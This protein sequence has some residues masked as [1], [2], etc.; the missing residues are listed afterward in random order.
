MAGSDLPHL[1]DA[2]LEL[3]RVLWSE[4]PLSAR[5]IHERLSERG[6]SRSTTRTLLRRLVAKSAVSQAPFHG[7]QLYTTEVGRARGLASRIR[8]F[9]EQILQADPVSVVP[10][11][12]DSGSLDEG[13]IAELE[14]LLAEEAP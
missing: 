11:F 6:W 4:E 7:L 5:E 8:D 14:A 13:E 12:A 2:E 3:M 10:L 9:A 1:T